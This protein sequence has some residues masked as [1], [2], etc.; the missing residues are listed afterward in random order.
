MNFLN[1]IVKF[2]ERVEK[3]PTPRLTSALHAFGGRNYE[4][5]N[6]AKTAKT[7]FKKSRRGKIFVQP[8][9]VKRRKEVSGSKNARIKG[10]TV[11]N[12][13]F[14]NKK[15]TVKR[16]HCFAKNVAE[17]VPVPHKAGRSMS[18]KTKQLKSRVKN[19]K[20]E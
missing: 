1:G 17:N 15:H 14:K 3:L 13:P 6:T 2:C 12:N 10:M 19:E 16:S 7:L 11:K 4:A 18:S 8:E 5:S 9:A 20:T